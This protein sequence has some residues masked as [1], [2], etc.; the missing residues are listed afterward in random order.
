M[1]RPARCLVGVSRSH[2]NPTPHCPSAQIAHQIFVL[3]NLKF[4]IWWQGNTRDQHAAESKRCGTEGRQRRKSSRSHLPNGPLTCCHAT[5]YYILI[6]LGYQGVHEMRSPQFCNPN[7]V[8]PAQMTSEGKCGRDTTA[9]DY[10]VMRLRAHFIAPVD[11]VY[12]FF[13]TA[14]DAANL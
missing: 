14:D 6:P 7:Y 5:L 8:T 1:H 3:S 11:S 2:N 4:G 12:T 10:Y 13:A 9:P